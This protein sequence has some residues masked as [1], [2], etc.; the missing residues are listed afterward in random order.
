[1]SKK[2]G[3]FNRDN[4][5]FYTDEINFLVCTKMSEN[6]LHNS[7]ENLWNATGTI[8]SARLSGDS[9]LNGLFFQ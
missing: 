1:M 5:N 7:L 4:V 6:I 2:G 9:R 8:I 3:P